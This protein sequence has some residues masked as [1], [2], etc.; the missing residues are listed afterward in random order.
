[1]LQLSLLFCTISHPAYSIPQSSQTI[2]IYMD[3]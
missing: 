3:H 1:M 2:P